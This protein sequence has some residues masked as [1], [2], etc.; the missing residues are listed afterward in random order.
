MG[1]YWR[2]QLK[3][4]HPDHSRQSKGTLQ[5]IPY[6]SFVH[7]SSKYNRKFSVGSMICNS[8]LKIAN[9]EK[10]DNSEEVTDNVG[11]S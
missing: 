3:S 8:H 4:Q 5:T 6:E 11:T 1:I 9:K 2:A 7:F 10:L